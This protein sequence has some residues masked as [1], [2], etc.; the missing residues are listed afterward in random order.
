M[1][2]QV[3]SL[4]NSLPSL[5]KCRVKIPPKHKVGVIGCPQQTIQ[6]CGVRSSFPADR[7]GHRHTKVGTSGLLKLSRPEASEA[8]LEGVERSRITKFMAP[9]T[10]EYHKVRTFKRL[11]V[12]VWMKEDR[13]RGRLYL[14]PKTLNP[15]V[16]ASG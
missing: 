12:G 10:P 5:A 11:K 6:H 9:S 14:R 15:A 8:V 4:L 3:G 1:Q 16:R 13:C 7:I 2:T